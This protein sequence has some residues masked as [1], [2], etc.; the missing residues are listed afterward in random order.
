MLGFRHCS[1]QVEAIP[2]G[3]SELAALLGLVRL[4]RYLASDTAFGASKRSIVVDC[5]TG[6]TAIG[7]QLSRLAALVVTCWPMP[8]IVLEL[9]SCL[10]SQTCLRAK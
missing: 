5:G 6:T 9:Q 4:V 2:E 1:A 7:A 10:S 8:P 3:A